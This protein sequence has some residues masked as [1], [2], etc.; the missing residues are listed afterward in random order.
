MN[1][2]LAGEPHVDDNAWKWL[3]NQERNNS[4]CIGHE[5]Q[6][7]MTAGA[8]QGQSGSMHIDSDSVERRFM[9][10]MLSK[11]VCLS[12]C[13]WAYFLSNRNAC[14]LFHLGAGPARCLC[15]KCFK[16]P[17]FSWASESEAILH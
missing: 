3:L 10:A 8:T 13:A 4:R 17:T 11:V 15:C 9:H 2:H 16:G 1:A 12:S 6:P 14:G 7:R 5:K